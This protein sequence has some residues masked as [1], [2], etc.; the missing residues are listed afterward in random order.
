MKNT[1]WPACGL[2]E[3]KPI[4]PTDE[5]LGANQSARGKVMEDGQVYKPYDAQPNAHNEP[6]SGTMCGQLKRMY[7]VTASYG[8]LDPKV[9]VDLSLA[10]TL[11][12]MF[13]V[14]L[15][16]PVMA[17]GYYRYDFATEVIRRMERQL[18]NV[19]LDELAVGQIRL[20]TLLILANSPRFPYRVGRFSTNEYR[21]YE[22]VVKTDAFKASGMNGD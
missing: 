9:S 4:F 18:D 7:H 10:K 8:E 16:S 22:F 12:Y 1:V 17:Y 15:P 6:V 11:S 21:Y 20:S 14:P 19:G 2:D 13:Q 3:D 5:T